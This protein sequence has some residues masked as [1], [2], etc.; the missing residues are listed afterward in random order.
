MWTIR[1]LVEVVLFVANGIYELL[2]RCRDFRE[3]E[4]G[5]YR[6][7]QEAARKMLEVALKRM[8]ER[9]L[10]QRDRERLEVVHTKT[11]KVLTAFGEIEV[12][13]RYYR[14]REAG[15]GKFLLDEALGLE[16]RQRLSPWLREVVGKL[17]VEV[18]Y[19]RAAGFLGELVPGVS[20]MGM[21]QVVQRAGGRER[22]AAEA[23]RAAVF[24]RGEAPVGERKVEELCVEADGVLVR[25]RSVGKK[26][27]LIEVKLAV[28]YEGKEEVSPGRKVLRQRRVVGA[29]AESE[30]FWEEVVTDFACKWDWA[31][32][33]RCLVGADGAA[34]LKAGCEYFP[35]ALYRLDPYHLLRALLEGLAHDAGAYERVV[36]AIAAGDWGAVERALGEAERR[37]RG[38]YRRRVRALWGYLRENWEGICSSGEGK[39]LGAIEGEVFHHLGR[40]MKRHGARWSERGA[41]HLARLLAAR[42]NGELGR[43]LGHGRR[44]EA[45]LM[46]VAVGSRMIEPDSG[47]EKAEDVCA[48]LRARVPA[49]TGPYA[50]R[51]W[52]KYVLR[53]LTRLGVQVS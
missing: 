25:G 53:E 29:V 31:S 38:E 33:K 23:A 5:I 13:R 36:E 4:V 34:W 43:A 48:W 18:P 1:C 10:L 35:G 27:R 15:E 26:R 32:L 40:R 30:D 12:K 7:V 9:L 3:L 51:P 14:D 46:K 20:A 8:D 45:E 22:S 52:V 2:G 17:A 47:G 44:V 41:D 49:L 50:G 42:A 6:L 24:E 37:S 11:R 39:R 19:R 21:W 28:G 16:P